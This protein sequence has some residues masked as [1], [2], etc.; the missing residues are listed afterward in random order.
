MNQ[1]TN[2]QSIL[3]LLTQVFLIYAEIS[4]IV[5][6]IIYIMVKCLSISQLLLIV[7]FRP[8]FLNS[9]VHEC[10]LMPIRT[11]RSYANE[12]RFNLWPLRF[13]VT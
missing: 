6:N 2:N 4:K 12:W 8:F 1:Q 3:S 11:L 13:E 9:N 5:L 10:R 7:I